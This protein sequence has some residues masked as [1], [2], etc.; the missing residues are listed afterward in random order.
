MLQDRQL[1][2]PKEKPLK[3]R[4]WWV[5]KWVVTLLIVSYLVNFFQKQDSGLAGIAA[6]LGSVLRSDN[7]GYIA[8]LLALVPLNWSFEAYKWQLLARK[9]VPVSFSEAFRSTLTGLAVGVAVPAQVGDTLGR[10]GSLR[11]EARLKTLGAA[12][13]SNGIQF[14][15]SVLGGAVGWWYAAADLGLSAEIKYLINASILVVLLGG[16]VVGIFRHRL[17]HWRTKRLWALKLQGNLVVISRYSGTELGQAMA[18][19]G[20]RYLVFVVQFVLALWL[21]G[22]DLP[23]LDL[24]LAVALIYLAKTLLPALNALGDL[25]VRQFVALY[26]FAPYQLADE[27]VVAATLLVWLVNILAPLLVGVYFVWKF[28]WSARYA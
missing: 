3:S 8:V 22:I 6:V 28:K 27:Q 4:A 26:V 15:V 21:V 24:L 13:V 7:L 9:A 18:I 17:V 11:S 5:A 23:L 14:Y 19:G 1:F 25:G 16:L 2:P 10:I 20:L 12:L